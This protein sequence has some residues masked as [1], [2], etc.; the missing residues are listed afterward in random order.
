MIRT[1]LIDLATDSHGHYATLTLTASYQEL[2]A[3]QEFLRETQEDDPRAIAGQ[4]LGCL[5][6]VFEDLTRYVLEEEAALQHVNPDQ[7][8]E[9]D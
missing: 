1:E 4:L 9:D 8:L 7:E 6:E 5:T 2:D 3:L